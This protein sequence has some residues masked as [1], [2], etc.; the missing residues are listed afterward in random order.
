MQLVL[1]D[2][3][4]TLRQQGNNAMKYFLIDDAAAD[5][6]RLKSYEE[7]EQWLKADKSLASHVARLLFPAIMQVSNAAR[8]VDYILN[9]AMNK[10]AIRMHVDKVGVLPDSLEKLEVVPALLNPYTNKPYELVV[11]PTQNKNIME[12]VVS[13]EVPG[14]LPMYANWVTPFLIEVNAQK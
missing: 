2:M 8:R 14:I 4:D 13:G 5:K 1:L 6:A 7:F 12:V 3:D 11:K 9:G 10:E